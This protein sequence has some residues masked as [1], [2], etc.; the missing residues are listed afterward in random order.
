MEAW[1]DSN[2]DLHIASTSAVE[3]LALKGWHKE[4]KVRNVNN[5]EMI[6][7]SALLV[8]YATEPS[9][10]LSTKTV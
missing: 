1:F 10:P 2:G 5:V 9:S 7:A 6:P 3:M 8:H 4:S